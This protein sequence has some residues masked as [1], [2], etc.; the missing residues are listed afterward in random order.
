MRLFQSL[1]FYLNEYGASNNLIIIFKILDVDLFLFLKILI[2]IRD[3]PYVINGTFQ[4]VDLQSD[5][6]RFSGEKVLYKNSK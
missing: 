4:F 3:F 5:Y 2:F 6:N 1:R